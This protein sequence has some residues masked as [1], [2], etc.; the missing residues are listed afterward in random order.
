MTYIGTGSLTLR[1]DRIVYNPSDATNGTI[2][3]N[4]NLIYNPSSFNAGVGNNSNLASSALDTSL[5]EL[6]LGRVQGHLSGSPGTPFVH[7]LKLDPGLYDGQ[8]VHFLVSQLTTGSNTIEM[9][10]EAFTF[11]NSNTIQISG[12]FFGEEIVKTGG[13]EAESGAF[14][15]GRAASF[16]CIWSATEN[17]WCILY[18][19]ATG[20]GQVDLGA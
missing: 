7:V 5:V 6:E 20:T 13:A 19:S 3:L 10:G 17:K 12:N 14:A 8:V 1:A 2:Q 11:N 16:G 9:E 4:G 18:R 15:N